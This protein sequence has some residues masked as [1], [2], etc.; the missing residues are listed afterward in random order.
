[1]PIPSYT[2]SFMKS[3]DFGQQVRTFL[4]LGTFNTYP[5][6]YQFLLS[7]SISIHFMPGMDRQTER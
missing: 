4:Q 5:N 1:M 3:E 2:F 6:F 7:S